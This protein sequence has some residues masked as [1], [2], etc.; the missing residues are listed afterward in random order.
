MNSGKQNA[1]SSPVQR[2]AQKELIESFL[3][4]FKEEDSNMSGDR[5]AAESQVAESMT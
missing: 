3:R 4:A 1:P 2:G 5:I